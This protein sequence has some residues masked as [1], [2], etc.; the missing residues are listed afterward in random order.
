MTLNQF[1]QAKSEFSHVVL[2]VRNHIAEKYFSANSFYQSAIRMKG[3]ER[4]WT[5]LTSNAK[6]GDT[7]HP[8]AS[9]QYVHLPN[10]ILSHTNRCVN[11]IKFCE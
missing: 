7:L 9:K 1:S 6:F 3:W 10:Y 11:T 8:D 5:Y 2:M 4:H